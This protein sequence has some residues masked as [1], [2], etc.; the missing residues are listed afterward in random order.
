[1]KP[2]KEPGRFGLKQEAQLL[3]GKVDCIVSYCLSIMPVERVE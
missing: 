2:L 3:L 1:M